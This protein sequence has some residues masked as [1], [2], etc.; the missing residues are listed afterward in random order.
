M[1]K[2]KLKPDRKA[3]WWVH[4]IYHDNKQLYIGEYQLP[5]NAEI[6]TVLQGAVQ[7]V[8]DSPDPV[9]MIVEADGD[10]ANEHLQFLS[11]IRED[12]KNRNPAEIVW[13]SDYYED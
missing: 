12:V 5:F 3:R 6:E 9:D 10:Y 2:Q 11:V 7:E 13:S 4:A 8:S 1:N